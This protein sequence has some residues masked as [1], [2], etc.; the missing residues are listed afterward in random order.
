MEPPYTSSDCY[1]LGPFDFF[2]SSLFVSIG[3]LALFMAHVGYLHFFN[4]LNR[5]CS[6]S[7]NS[8]GFEHMVVALWYKVP[9]TLYLDGMLWWLSNCRYKSV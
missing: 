2:C 3:V 5:C 8:V 6:S 9:A 4:A 7:C 1:F